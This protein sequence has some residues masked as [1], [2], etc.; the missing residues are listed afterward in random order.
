MKKMTEEQHLRRIYRAL[1]KNDRNK[2]IVKTEDEFVK[3]TLIRQNKKLVSK[4]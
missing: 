3:S 4:K 2:G 1:C